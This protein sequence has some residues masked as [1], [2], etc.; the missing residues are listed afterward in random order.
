MHAHAAPSP[1]RGEGGGE[2]VRDSPIGPS[3]L[4]PSLSP[5]G[6]GR[7]S[8]SRRCPILSKCGSHELTGGGAGFNRDGIIAKSPFEPP[9][10]LKGDMPRAERARALWREMRRKTWHLPR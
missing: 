6:R 3:P 1:R 4:T 7:R 5:L 10:H 2:G 9:A 8:R